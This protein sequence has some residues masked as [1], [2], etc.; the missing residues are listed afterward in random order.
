MDKAFAYRTGS[1]GS[2][3]DMTIVS[4]A[5][6]PLGTPAM[7]TQSLSFEVIVSENLHQY[8]HQQVWRS[9]ITTE[10]TKPL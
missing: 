1:K 9:S 6:I 4:S 8:R 3:P 10:V 5:L 7:C 2:V